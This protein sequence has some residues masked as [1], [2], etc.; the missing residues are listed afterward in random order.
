MKKTILHGVGMIKRFEETEVLHGIDIDVYAGDFTVIMGSS[1]SGK[2]TLLYAL[3][4]M[5]RLSEGSIFYREKEITKASEKELEALR[6][7][8]FGFVFQRTHLVSNLTLEE[9]IRMAGL[10]CAS[11]SEQVAG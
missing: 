2:S 1:G 8:E 7:G 9:N 10:V 6:A 4:G 11:M 3:S 5:D